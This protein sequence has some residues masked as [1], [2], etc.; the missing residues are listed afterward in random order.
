MGHVYLLK[1]DIRTL[2]GASR[3][4]R[5][6]HSTIYKIGMTDRAVHHRLI[7]IQQ[8]WWTKR[9]IEVLPVSAIAVRDPNAVETRF[10]QLFKAQRLYGKE[11]AEI[12]GGGWCSGDSEWF[13]S[14]VAK[15]ALEEFG[16]YSSSFFAPRLH[17]ISPAARPSSRNSFQLTIALSILTVLF[18]LVFLLIA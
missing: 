1:A 5:F 14:T 12:L 8:E 7:E 13:D 16:R 9:R 17:K 10:H 11:M 15:P 2:R 6:T 18:I 4:R 3:S